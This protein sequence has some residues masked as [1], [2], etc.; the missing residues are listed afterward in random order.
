MITVGYRLR[1][2]A[3]GLLILL[4]LWCASPVLANPL[5]AKMNAVLLLKSLQLVENFQDRKQ[6]RVLVLGNSALADELGVLMKRL[7][8]KAEHVKVFS[9]Q[10]PSVVKP[11]VIFVSRESLLQSAQLYSAARKVLTVTDNV[12]FS[13]QGVVLTLY[14]KEGL[15]GILLNVGSSRELGLQWSE[16]ILEVAD[17]I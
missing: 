3:K 6:V 9:N 7:G 14:N 4:P 2:I 13:R 1:W 17:L 15:P 5:P 12:D 16:E 11:D 10:K 8:S